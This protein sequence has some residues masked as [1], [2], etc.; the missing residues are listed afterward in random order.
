LRI[1]GYAGDPV[2]NDGVLTL[3][4]ADF[5]PQQKAGTL[6]QSDVTKIFKRL[7][8]F[9]ESSLKRDFHLQ[10]EESSPGY[11]LAEIIHS[12][13]ARLTRVRFFLLSNRI[14]SSRAESIPE[15]VVNGISVSFNIWDVSRLYRLA[16]SKKEREDI[17]IDLMSEF[18]ETLSC[19]PASVGD[20]GYKAYLVVIPATILSRLYERWGARLL[21]QNVR[22]FLQARGK[23][24]KG[25]RNTII[26]DP[27]MFFAYNNGI[28]ATAELVETTDSGSSVEITKLRN[29]QIVNGGQTTA[30]LFTTWKNDKVQLDTIFVQ[31]KLSVVEPED[32]I[33]V[34]PKISEYANSQNKVNAADFFSNHPFHIRIEEISRRLWAPSP[35][36][37]HQESKWFYERARGQYLDTKS[38]LTPAE[39]KTV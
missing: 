25:I 9:F 18:G 22:C 15:S 28:T 17:E 32:V 33:R 21:E 7:E 26:N 34:V 4:I 14:L 10:M 11:G 29:L 19:L 31:M 24:N 5:Y 1:D 35:D 39:K 38:R 8:N 12:R 30:S 2:E 3:F 13:Q 23:V 20:T 6:T 16:T 37:S 36:S 27:Q